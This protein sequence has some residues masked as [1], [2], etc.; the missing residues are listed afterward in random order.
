MEIGA[1]NYPI[2]VGPKSALSPPTS[3]FLVAPELTTLGWLPGLLDA[4]MLF[5]VVVLKITSASGEVTAGG[6]IAASFS[7]ASCGLVFRT[8]SVLVSHM[9]KH[10]VVAPV[11]LSSPPVLAHY[12]ALVL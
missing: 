4:L 5:V 11:A 12:I 8:N 7:C 2:T 1:I 9:A 10:T 6:A 3:L